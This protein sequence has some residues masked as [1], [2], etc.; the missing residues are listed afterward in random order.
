MFGSTLRGVGQD[1]DILIVGPAGE[2]LARLKE[3]IAAVGEEL[4]LHIIYMDQSEAVET[5]FIAREK[6]VS[7][8]KLAQ[9]GVADRGQVLT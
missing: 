6:C 2:A 3:E 8:S 5:D 4:P 7:F 1:V 9:T